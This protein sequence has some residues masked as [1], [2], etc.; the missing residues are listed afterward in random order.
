MSHPG[1]DWVAWR[2]RGSDSMGRWGG[3]GGGRW[4]GT[5]M[6]MEMKWPEKIAVAQ[7]KHASESVSL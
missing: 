6:C 3:G 7:N 5:M 2:L 4:C 1:M